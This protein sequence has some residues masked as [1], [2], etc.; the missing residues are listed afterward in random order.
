MK[1]RD[2]Q[3]GVPQFPYFDFINKSIHISLAIH[4][5]HIQ[6]VFIHN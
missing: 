1:P 2:T 3:Q 5:P 4:K 6:E